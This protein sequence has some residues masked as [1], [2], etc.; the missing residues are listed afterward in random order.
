MTQTCSGCGS[1]LPATREY[2]AWRADTDKPNGRCR[3]CVN[4]RQ[5][6]IQR[7][8]RKRHGAEFIARRRREYYEQEKSSGAHQRRSREYRRRNLELVRGIEK[9]NQHR[10][11][12]TPKGHITDNIRRAIRTSLQRKGVKSRGRKL[13]ALPYSAGRL[14][15]HLEGLF[16]TGMSW[17]NYGEWHIDHIRPIAS[18]DYSSVDDPEFQKCWALDNLQPLWA[19]ENFSKGATILAA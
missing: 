11:R 16:R 14:A 2:F 4:R 7:R 10:I 9:R 12:A 1:K 5:L 3:S 17:A 6:A 8:Y 19:S 13:S 18:F 15:E